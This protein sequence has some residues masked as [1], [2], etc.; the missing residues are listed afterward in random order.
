MEIFSKLTNTLTGVTTVAPVSGQDHV[1]ELECPE[2]DTVI[3]TEQTVPRWTDGAV[4]AYE[5][6][7]CVHTHLFRW[8][9]PEPVYV[10]DD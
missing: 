2:H 5:C 4:S 9:A 7:A 8:G 1:V 10:G 3:A 6:P